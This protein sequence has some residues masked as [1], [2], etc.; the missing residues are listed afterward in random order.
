[1]AFDL[2]EVFT[3]LQKR[4]YVADSSE[5]TQDL[6]YL[7]KSAMRG[8]QNPIYSYDTT[9]D[10]PNL[11]D[12]SADPESVA[13]VRGEENLYFKQ[14]GEWKPTRVYV[15]ETQ[16][17]SNG[18]FIYG[19][20]T[21]S[22]FSNVQYYPFSSPFTSTSIIGN[23]TVAK[24]YATGCRD[25]TN[26]KGYVAGGFSDP[27]QGVDTIESHPNAASGLTVTDVGS[28]SAAAYRVEGMTSSTD[29]YVHMGFRTN[30]PSP[31]FSQSTAIDKFAYGSTVTG[32]D[33][34]DI[35]AFGES[36]NATEDV[37]RGAGYIKLATSTSFET[38]PFAST[39]GFT[40]SPAATSSFQSNPQAGAAYGNPT[41]GYFHQP[42]VVEKLQYANSTP[43]TVT[44]IVAPSAPAATFPQAAAPASSTTAGY[45]AGGTPTYPTA[46]GT[47][48]TIVVTRPFANDTS[49]TA[50]NDALTPNTF[51]AALQVAGSHW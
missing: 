31:G 46:P 29:A 26:E 49:T 19:G 7:L 25:Y 50:V 33:F 40:T 38:F 16:Q 9:A 42:Q 8:D 43:L 11:L 6:I 21:S 34:G 4:A 18:A 17:G 28:L 15:E 3:F 12:D 35:S 23:L 47:P 5:A 22:Q 45:V 32:V 24:A 1:M 30:F 39:V 14:A 41:F 36:L 13:Y 20:G 51:N 2:R 27:T 10:L 44:T 48:G 37:V